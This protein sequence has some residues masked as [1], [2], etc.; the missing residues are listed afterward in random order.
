MSSGNLMGLFI[1]PVRSISTCV[2]EQTQFL[3]G[4]LELSPF[5]TI[6]DCTKAQSRSMSCPAERFMAEI[7]QHRACSAASDCHERASL[8]PCARGQI[9]EGAYRDHCGLV[10][11]SPQYACD[12]IAHMQHCAV[13]P[14]WTRCKRMC[15]KRRKIFERHVVPV[16]IFK[17][18]YTNVRRRCNDS[19][20]L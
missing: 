17:P 18:T 14:G 1:R 4:G 3:T 8:V 2:H 6:L 11:I 5:N 9:R 7:V 20:D 10:C 16:S 15:W 13:R 19:T 12:G